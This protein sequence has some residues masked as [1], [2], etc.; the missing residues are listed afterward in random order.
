MPRLVTSRDI[1][2]T[3]SLAAARRTAHDA[4]VLRGARRTMAEDRY[5]LTASMPLEEEASAAV[6]VLVFLSFVPF[7]TLK[8]TR[9]QSREVIL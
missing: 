4:L 6:S 5:Y 2:L 8:S 9:Q 1:C 3:G 7:E